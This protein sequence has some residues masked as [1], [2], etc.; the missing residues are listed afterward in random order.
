VE[1]FSA[2]LQLARVQIF[3]LTGNACSISIVKIVNNNEKNNRG[4]GGATEP[5]DADRDRPRKYPARF[6]ARAQITSFSF[7]NALIWVVRS[8]SLCARTERASEIPSE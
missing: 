5:S 6:P 1:C 2:H 7:L 4:R 3:R 8:R